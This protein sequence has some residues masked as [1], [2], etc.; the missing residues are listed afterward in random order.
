MKLEFAAE[1]RQFDINGVRCSDWGAIC[2]DPDELLSLRSPQGKDF[3]ITAKSWGYYMGPSLNGRLHRQGYKTALVVNEF[4]KLF[5]MVV[6]ET[7]IDEFKT[8]LKTDQD[9]RILCWLDEWLKEE[10]R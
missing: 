2:L 9:N 7:R 4:N 5:V 8:Y 6:D 10:P 3:D 1:P